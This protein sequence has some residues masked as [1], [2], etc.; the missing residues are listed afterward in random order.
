MEANI[1]KFREVTEIRDEIRELLKDVK[2]L[3]DN[4]P[5]RKKFNALKKELNDTEQAIKYNNMYLF[6]EAQ[7]I[8]NKHFNKTI[9][10]I[11]ELI[12]NIFGEKFLNMDNSRNHKYKNLFEGIEGTT[13]K[14]TKKYKYRLTTKTRVSYSNFILDI[15]VYIWNENGKQQH[16]DFKYLAQFEN[17]TSFKSLYDVEEFKNFNLKTEI[18]K[19]QKYEEQKKKLDTLKSGLNNS[20]MNLFS[21]HYN[22]DTF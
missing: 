22:K 21:F 18:K 10:E 7:N 4:T 1:T 20:F 8:V 14:E 19:L 2:S 16:S 6:I 17:A 15:S 9:P 13:T 5:E 3:A 12:K 11:N